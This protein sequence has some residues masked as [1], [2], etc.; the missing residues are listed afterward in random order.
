MSSG[1][2]IFGHNFSRNDFV[3]T[4]IWLLISI[5]NLFY[6]SRP[7]WF[8]SEQP[9]FGVAPTYLTLITNEP[10]LP[11]LRWTGHKKDEL[12]RDFLICCGKSRWKKH[13]AALSSPQSQPKAQ[14]AIASVKANAARRRRL[15]RQDAATAAR[16]GMT[17][18]ASRLIQFFSRKSG[19]APLM[20]SPRENARQH[21]GLNWSVF[22]FYLDYVFFKYF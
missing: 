21:D 8:S 15:R 5:Q 17:A 18:A 20:R 22:E 6:S 1:L 2:S 9:A 19:W 4:P 3:W 13:A 10:W 14:T 11:G 7:F 12:S 16:L